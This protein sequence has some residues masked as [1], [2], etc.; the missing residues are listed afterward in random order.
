MMSARCPFIAEGWVKRATYDEPR[1]S[2]MVEMY[3]E[4]GF[5][6]HLEPFNPEFEPECSE[7]MKMAPERYK[8]IYTRRKHNDD[9]ILANG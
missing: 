8:T 4:I 3:R 1:L 6:V 2:E 5:E 9:D 7:C